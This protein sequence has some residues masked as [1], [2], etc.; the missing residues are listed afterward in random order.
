M[1][2]QERLKYILLKPRRKKTPNEAE[3]IFEEMTGNFE[4]YWKKTNYRS[5]KF[6][7][8]RRRIKIEIKYIKNND[9]ETTENQTHTQKILNSATAKREHYLEVKK[10][11]QISQ[12][13]VY[14]NIYKSESMI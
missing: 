11:N 4:H 5:S 12:Q 14:Q 9:S 8:P 7:E 13:L 2:M 1:I 10:K 6:R 3:K